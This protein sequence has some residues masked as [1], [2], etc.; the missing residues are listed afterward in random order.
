MNCNGA[1]G[2]GEAGGLRRHVAVGRAGLHATRL[3]RP[4]RPTRPTSLLGAASHIHLHM[5]VGP[6]ALEAAATI[7]RAIVGL[8]ANDVL[9]RR[10]ENRGR[11]ELAVG[12]RARPFGV[13]LNRARAPMF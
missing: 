8:D 12:L 9:A 5:R 7:A 3:T 6:A 10:G 1:G 4:T 13:E 2:A 11:G